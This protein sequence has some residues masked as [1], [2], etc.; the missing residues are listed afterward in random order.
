[1]SMPTLDGKLITFIISRSS[2]CPLKWAL[3]DTKVGAIEPL[4]RAEMDPDNENECRGIFM[5]VL[6]SRFG[7]VC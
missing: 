2:G 3:G 1:M 7:A 5:V 4:Q 6:K